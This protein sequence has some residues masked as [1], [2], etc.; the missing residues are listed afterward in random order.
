MVVLVQTCLLFHSTLFSTALMVTGRKI[1]FWLQ[2][3]LFLCT[4]VTSTEIT[5]VKRYG[6]LTPSCCLIWQNFMK[7]SATEQ[8][9]RYR[10]GLTSTSFQFSGCSIIC[11][12]F[13]GNWLTYFLTYF[14]VACDL[15]PLPS[16]PSWGCWGPCHVTTH[17]SLQSPFPRASSVFS[18]L[19]LF[20]L[21]LLLPGK[22]KLNK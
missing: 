5:W 2:T 16:H 6:D 12:G 14:P 4:F 22:V 1:V 21:Q 13:L 11:W 17:F 15:L 19:C 18:L 20:V 10:C 9:P 8:I 3:Q 7:P